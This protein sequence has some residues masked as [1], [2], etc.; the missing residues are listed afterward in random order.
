MATPNLEQ[1]PD[2]VQLAYGPRVPLL[3]LAAGY[4]R[5]RHP[6]VLTVSIPKTALQLLGLPALGVPRLD[7]D[8]GLADLVDPAHHTPPPPRFNTNITNPPHPHRPRRPEPPPSP[9]G[10]SVPVGPVLLR[11]GTTLPPPND[12]PLTPKHPHA[13]PSRAANLDRLWIT[14][15]HPRQN[16]TAQSSA[17]QTT[18]TQS[19]GTGGTHME[20][21]VHAD[22]PTPGAPL[23]D[24]TFC[25]SGKDN[26]VSDATENAAVT[27]HTLHIKGVSI[28]YT[29][30]GGSSRHHRSEQLAAPTA[31]M[32]YVAFTE[33]RQDRGEPAR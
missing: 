20:E 19:E 10:P 9:G 2:G 30:T 28:A 8:P 1:T 18:T 32:F 22:E 31:K 27:Q 17:V 21:S 14:P 7:N 33:G 13:A 23:L 3:M 5:G 11:D 4:P 12:V 6:V 24:T 15:Q 29:A 16:R 25:G 26:S